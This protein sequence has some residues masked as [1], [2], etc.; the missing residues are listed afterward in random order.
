[1]WCVVLIRAVLMYQMGT[2]MV[3]ARAVCYGD[4]VDGTHAHAMPLAAWAGTNVC[5]VARGMYVACDTIVR[6]IV[7][8]EGWARAAVTHA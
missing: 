7:W 2:H 6:F 3:W 1:M 4:V 8:R 5:G